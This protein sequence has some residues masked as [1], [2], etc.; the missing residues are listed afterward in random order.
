VLCCLDVDYQPT[1]V[2][3]ACVGFDAWTDEV[4]RIE[5]VVRSLATTPAAYQPGAFYTREL[6]YL[7]EAL[8][9]MPELDAIVVDAYVWLGPDRPGLGWH[10]HEARGGRGA[11]IGVAKTQFAGAVAVEVVRGGSARPLYVTAIG[12]APE[13]AAGHVRSMH[14]AHR[15]PTLIRRVDALARGHAHP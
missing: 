4:A 5:V 13:V 1:N 8:E 9:R 6:P 12:E 7:L 15:I 10:L 3:T 11:V 14:G 2:T